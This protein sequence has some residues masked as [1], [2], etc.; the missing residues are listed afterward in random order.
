[1]VQGQVTYPNP[2]HPLLGGL[3]DYL[4]R[5]PWRLINFIKGYGT[6]SGDH[7]NPL[8]PL[9]GGLRDYELTLF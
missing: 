8:H 7:P 2:L 6:G 3:R 9:L 5:S 1:M 4:S